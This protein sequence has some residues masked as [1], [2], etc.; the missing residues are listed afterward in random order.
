MHVGMKVG[1][2][3]STMRDRIEFEIVTHTQTH[4]HVHSHVHLLGFISTSFFPW[5]H[6]L[7]YNSYKPFYHRQQLSSYGLTWHC[8]FFFQEGELR[9]LPGLPSLS[10]LITTHC[11]L[12][13]NYKSLLTLNFCF[14]KDIKEEEVQSIVEGGRYCFFSHNIFLCSITWMSFPCISSV[15]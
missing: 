10:N 2:D 8:F 6:M 9:L 14:F 11:H 3:V 7:T 12:Y 1:K 15:L 5:P 13:E 4:T